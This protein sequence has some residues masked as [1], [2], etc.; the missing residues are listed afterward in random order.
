MTSVRALFG[1]PQTV[2]Q[3]KL[4][5]GI[6]KGVHG[7]AEHCGTACKRCRNKLDQRDR[8]IPGECGINHFA[9]SDP[10]G[11][12]R[13]LGLSGLRR[14]LKFASTDFAFDI[15]SA[16]CRHVMAAVN[17]TALRHWGLCGNVRGPMRGV[18]AP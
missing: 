6:N 7:L 16:R 10:G 17:H 18:C 8:E 9:R 2:E 1:L 14:H 5:D 11:N 4:V 3:Q 13:W 15:S 12:G